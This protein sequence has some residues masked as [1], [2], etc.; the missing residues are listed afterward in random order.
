M[1]ASGTRDEL[2]LI[3]AD[4]G[5]AERVDWDDSEPEASSFGLVKSYNF[6]SESLADGI[7]ADMNAFCAF[8]SFLDRCISRLGLDRGFFGAFDTFGLQLDGNH[9]GMLAL[10]RG[11]HP[12]R[13]AFVELLQRVVFRASVQVKSNDTSRRCLRSIVQIG[14]LAH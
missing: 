2:P 6:R 5:G 8:F 12:T 13:Q 1:D 14:Y 3:S 9:P 7:L 11:L 4:F 10:H